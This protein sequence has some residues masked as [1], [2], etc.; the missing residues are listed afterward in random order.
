VPDDVHAVEA[1]MVEERGDAVGVLFHG[2]S[3]VGGRIGIAEPEAVNQDCP[4]VCESM[5]VSNRREG[6][7]GCATKPVQE[8]DGGLIAGEVVVAQRCADPSDAECL[9]GQYS[10]RCAE[11]VAAAASYSA[12]TIV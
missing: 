10:L 8:N 3:E 4:G 11:L 7:G 5:V 12:A 1:E 6:F 2:V 9:Y